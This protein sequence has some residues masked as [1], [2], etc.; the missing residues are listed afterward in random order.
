M[1]SKNMSL[2]SS[3]PYIGKLPDHNHDITADNC[4]RCK[5]EHNLDLLVAIADMAYLIG[6]PLDEQESGD[7]GDRM[8]DLTKLAKFYFD[9]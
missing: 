6:I 7:A 9:K 3:L 5:I 4:K 8:L 2:R 1:K